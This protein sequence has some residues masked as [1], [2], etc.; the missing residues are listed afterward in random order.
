[1]IGNPDSEKEVKVRF[2]RKGKTMEVQNPPI[3]IKV[4]QLNY[5]EPERD[6]TPDQQ[7]LRK[8]VLGR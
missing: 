4:T 1:L 7:R 8:L 3:R 5:I 6:L 2:S